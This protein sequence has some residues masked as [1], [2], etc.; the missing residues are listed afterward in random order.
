MGMGKE[1]RIETGTGTRTG[2]R[3]AEERCR[4]ASNRTRVVDVMWETGESWVE[5]KIVDK[6]GLV[7]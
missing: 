3:T 5:I 7:Q 1:T 4:S 6:K 2:S